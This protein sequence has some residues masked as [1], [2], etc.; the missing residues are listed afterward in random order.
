M[1]RKLWILI[2]FALWVIL[3]GSPRKWDDLTP[4]ERLQHDINAT[5]IF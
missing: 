2:A 5:A 3:L 1:R 4:E